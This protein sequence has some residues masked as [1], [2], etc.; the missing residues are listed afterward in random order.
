MR[1]D[2][3]QVG[4]AGGTRRRRRIVGKTPPQSWT[5][6]RGRGMYDYSNDRLVPMNDSLESRRTATDRALA[7]DFV[8]NPD[9]K[10]IVF[11]SKGHFTVPDTI[12]RAAVQVNADCVKHHGCNATLAR[13][14]KRLS[15]LSVHGKKAIG[16]FIGRLLAMNIADIMR[17]DKAN[18]LRENPKDYGCPDLV[19]AEFVKKFEEARKALENRTKSKKLSKAVLKVLLKTYWSRFRHGGIEIK[20]T[21]GQLV[22]Q[23]HGRR[24]ASFA[25]HGEM[26]FDAP[27]I[28]VLSAISWSAHH[29]GSSRILGL[30]WDYVRG[31]PQIVAAFYA[32]D[33]TARDYGEQ[34]NPTATDGHTTN[35]TKIKRQGK[36]K[37]EFIFVLNDRRYVEAIRRFLPESGV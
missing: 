10:K 12:I 4:R 2:A 8:V 24:K 1:K 17:P 14:G 34:G 27:R 20:L 22:S 32:G 13:S 28:D 26:P 21:C 35:Q 30:L 3:K 19:P 11:D 16:N 37:F 18:G 23:N 9:L 6:F 7:K 29:D 15:M 31:V 36:D 33:L 25:P 5:H